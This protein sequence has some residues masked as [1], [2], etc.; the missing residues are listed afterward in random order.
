MTAY[1]EEQEQEL[2]ALE[3]I[4]PEELEILSRE[5]PL[6]FQIAVKSQLV[7]PFADDAV[8]DNAD[9]DDDDAKDRSGEA[10]IPA[11]ECLL[12]FT[13]PETYP[14]A[15]PEMEVVDPDE[16]NLDEEDVKGLLDK[17]KQV[18]D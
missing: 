10:E 2:E 16:S 15:L 5:K 11:A 3:S 4:Y 12:E 9:N 1:E 7:D 13:L 18:S 8:D 6:K 17:L 14:D